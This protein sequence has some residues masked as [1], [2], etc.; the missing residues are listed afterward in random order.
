MSGP[1]T[2][3]FSANP[4]LALLS[5]AAIRAGVAVVQ[6]YAHAAALQQEH[7]EHAA[8]TRA[9]QDAAQQQ[10]QAALGE[11]AHAALRELKQLEVLAERLGMADAVR[12]TKPAP[13]PSQQPEA[14]AA[15]LGALQALAAQLRPVLLTEAARQVE[16]F[17]EQPSELTLPAAVPR[18]LGQRL[19]ARIAQLGPPPQ[20]LT[21]LA[22]E[23]DQSLPGARAD[24]LATELR[25]R[26]QAHV[27][28][29]QQQQVQAATA[30]IV[31][32]SLKD[33]GYQVEEIGSTL[34][35]EGGVVHF[36]RL[37]WG[38]YMVRMRVDAKAAT[39][40]F[41][42][43]RAVAAGQNE[44]S[45]LDHL[46]E[47][48]WCSEFPAL[49]KALQARGVQLDVTRRLAAGELPVQ[50]VDA[51]KLPKF[52]DEE[53]STPAASRGLQRKLP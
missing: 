52:A 17:A 43:V 51:D 41:N 46:A 2:V 18:T 1:I 44:R 16:Q 53:V 48:R 7:D 13:P 49:L 38:D 30:T 12:A 39:A 14:L 8:R 19:L 37:G 34:F 32:Q 29:L 10:G 4:V 33:L 40:N 27:E 5:A 11:A 31:E 9:R 28:A 15:Y 21:S 25:A 35:V 22:L 42:V 26:I 47:D 24:L 23:L 36:R 20:R 6:G 3:G 50:L 45:V